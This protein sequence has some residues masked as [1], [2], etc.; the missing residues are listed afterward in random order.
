MNRSII[1]DG[2]VVRP[3]AKINGSVIGLRTLIGENAIIEDSL[4]MGA[5]Y[6]ETLEE[7][8]VVPGCLPMGVGPNTVI[9]KAILDK[10]CRVGANVKLI[11][12][13][14]VTEANLEDRGVIIKDGIMVVVK[15][16]VIPSGT[17]I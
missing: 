1:G 4:L 13:E 9:R 7:C 8:E 2:C 10:N 5:D 14:G 3:G 11:N 17:I 12:K 15:D 6:Y 16:S